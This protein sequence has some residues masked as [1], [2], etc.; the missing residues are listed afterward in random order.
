MSLG[1]FDTRL[2][3]PDCNDLRKEVLT[4]A[5]SSLY[6]IHPGSTKMYKDLKK[7]FWWNNI[8][9][10]VVEHVAKCLTC[11]QVKIEHQRPSEEL[12]PL[13]T[14]HGSGMT[15]PWISL[16]PCLKLVRDTT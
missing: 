16:P 9:Q 12:Q 2:W 14:R 15:S 5:D 7:H 1:R 4:E 8:K 10:D 11:Q 3:V 6:S 13:T